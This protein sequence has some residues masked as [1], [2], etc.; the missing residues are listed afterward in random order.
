MWK[1]QKRKMQKFKK[2]PLVIDAEQF[3]SYD[4]KI[5]GVC[6]SCWQLI[7]IPHIHTLEGIVT[8]SLYDWI[9]IGT[10][11]EPYPCKPD[12]FEIV[13]EKINEDN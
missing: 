5:N 13:Y 12:I 6:N 11:D 8:I 4:Q 2:R 1:E 3:T 10:H 7:N 9:I